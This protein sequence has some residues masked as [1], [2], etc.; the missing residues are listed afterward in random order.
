MVDF[1]RNAVFVWALLIAGT[2]GCS[3]KRLDLIEEET[4]ESETTGSVSTSSNSGSDADP[5]GTS[6]DARSGMSNRTEDSRTGDATSSDVTSDVSQDSTGL[7]FG[8]PPDRPFFSFGSCAECIWPMN[9]A[10]TDY[11]PQGL[12]CDGWGNCSPYC[13]SDRDCLIREGN[14]L[15]VCDRIRHSCRGCGHD[16]ECGEGFYCA[17][18]RC[19]PIPQ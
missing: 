10:D 6:S 16:R 8:C 9:S 15:P 13:S 5:G 12:V 19:V 4:I 7:S 2:A 14:P 11:C 1:S 3:M 17:F 18:P